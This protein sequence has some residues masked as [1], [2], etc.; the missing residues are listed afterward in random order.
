MLLKELALTSYRNYKQAS[1]QFLPL[2]NIVVG[3]NGKGK[4]NLLEAIYFLAR[5]HSHRTH[6]SRELVGWGA[7]AS[8]IKGLIER[9]GG[10]SLVEATITT[11]GQKSVRIG[12]VAQPANDLTSGLVAVLFAPEHLRIVQGDPEQRRTFLDDLL[13]QRSPRYEH[14]RRQYGRILRQR[15]ALLRSIA[16]GQESREAL[17]AWDS[18]LVEAG[19]RILAER[20]K[21][22]EELKGRCRR[23]YSQVA[24]GEEDGLEIAYVSQLLRGASLSEVREKFIRE[25]R[26]RQGEEI[27]RGVSL[28]GPHRDDLSVKV[29]GVNLRTFGSQGE[30]RTASLALKMAELKLLTEELGDQPVML[31]DDVM[32]ELDRIRREA[33]T[34]LIEGGGQTI[35]TTTNLGYFGEPSLSKAKLIDVEKAGVLSCA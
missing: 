25:L 13:V 22:V 23:A 31:L 21:L 9:E 15:N 14:S 35:I 6:F 18:Q 3:S 33:L 12:G 30:Q 2:L 32:S 7:G 11:R 34:S 27:E 26:A 20:F 5:G 1:F 24:K 10:P 28:V 29:S 16:A 19:V 17:A 8:L 4:T